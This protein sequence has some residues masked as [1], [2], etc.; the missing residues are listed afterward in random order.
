MFNVYTKFVKFEIN[1]NGALAKRLP[2]LGVVEGTT[3]GPFQDVPPQKRPP[4]P[5]SVG[6]VPHIPALG[7]G[8]NSK[9]ILYTKIALIKKHGFSAFGQ[10]FCCTQQK[11]F[12][13]LDVLF[14]IN[15]GNQ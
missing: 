3:W 1:I 12:L 9:G 7:M 8:V 11:R 5:L 4:S 15:F 2:N 6:V 10:G 13:H 14:V